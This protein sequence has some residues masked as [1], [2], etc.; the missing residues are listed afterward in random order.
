MEPPQVALAALMR[1]RPSI[2]DEI[3]VTLSRRAKIVMPGAANGQGGDNAP[4][5]SVLVSRIRQLFEVPHGPSMWR[6]TEKL[7]GPSPHDAL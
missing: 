4:S 7:K 5:I 6:Q 2:A 3:G 1:D